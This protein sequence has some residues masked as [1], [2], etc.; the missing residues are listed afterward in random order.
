M[1][2]NVTSFIYTF[3][4]WQIY[5]LPGSISEHMKDFHIYVISRSNKITVKPDSLMKLNGAAR[6]EFLIQNGPVS[7]PSFISIPLLYRNHGVKLKTQYPYMN[8][9]FVHSDG[10][11]EKW[12]ASMFYAYNYGPCDDTNLEILYIGQAY[13]NKGD[14][15]VQ[16]RLVSHSTLQKI[17]AEA[18]RDFPGYDIWISVL[19]FTPNVITSMNGIIES[20]S[21]DE[22]D[23]ERLKLYAN[24]PITEEHIINFTEAA[25]IRYFQPHYNKMYKNNFPD[26]SHSSYEECYELDLNSIGFEIIIP[27]NPR[28]FWSES[29]PPEKYHSALYRLPNADDR[30]RFFDIDQ[31]FPKKSHLDFIDVE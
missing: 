23:M 17:L 10:K 7:R 21:S 2:T 18:Q 15:A 8:F 22:Q 12:D 30:I 3:R 20:E 31:N 13:G 24:I 29:A 4:P 11:A 6:L 25:M 28:N 1:I 16:D 9:E 27:G 5:D 26:S 19:K 14:R